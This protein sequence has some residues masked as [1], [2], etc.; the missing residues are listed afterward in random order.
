[1]YFDRSEFVRS[2]VQV[3]QTELPL[4]STYDAPCGFIWTKIMPNGAISIYNGENFIQ[5]LP[6]I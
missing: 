4:F 3:K 2:G 1:M 5:V 6:A